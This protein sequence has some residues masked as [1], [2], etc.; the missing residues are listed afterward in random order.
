[1]NVRI[2]TWDWCMLVS[3][4]C[5][6]ALYRHCCFHFTSL[7][8]SVCACTV[9]W[10]T[11][12]CWLQPHFLYLFTLPFNEPGSH[13]IQYLVR[14]MRWLTMVALRLYQNRWALST[15]TSNSLFSYNLW[16]FGMKIKALFIYLHES[17]VVWYILGCLSL[18]FLNEFMF[19]YSF[20]VSHHP[21]MSAGHAENEH[22]I[23]DITSKVKTKF[24]GNSI[25][26][27]PVGR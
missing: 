13:S 16:C 24:L 9:W 25:D 20:Q 22:F 14:L 6:S 7:S 15:K 18:S 12:S 8:F 4:F 3:I 26:I 23:Y 11:Y 27:Y 19:L 5:I 21:P 2:H 17:Q 10:L 1:M